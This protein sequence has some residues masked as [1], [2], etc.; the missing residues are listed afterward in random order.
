MHGKIK[1]IQKT[2][3]L[4]KSAIQYGNYSLFNLE[5]VYVTIPC[6][7]LFIVSTIYCF[8]NGNYW[9]EQ[10]QWETD[11]TAVIVL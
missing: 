8:T 10:T 1:R 6:R 4:G 11:Y 9:N 3:S 5:H 7:K 2:I